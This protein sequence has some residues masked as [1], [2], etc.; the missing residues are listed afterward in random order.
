LSKAK[1]AACAVFHLIAHGGKTHVEV[2]QARDPDQEE[3]SGAVSPSLN[4]LYL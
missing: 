3:W 4:F 1:D 2:L